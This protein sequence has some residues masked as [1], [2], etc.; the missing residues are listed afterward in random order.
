M[1]DDR[2]IDRYCIHVHNYR[3]KGE[4]STYLISLIHYAL[5]STGRSVPRNVTFQAYIQLLGYI[6]TSYQGVCVP[7]LALPSRVISSQWILKMV[8]YIR[9]R[10]DVLYLNFHSFPE[11]LLHHVTHSPVLTLHLIQSYIPSVPAYSQF[12]SWSSFLKD[13]TR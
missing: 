1:L 6:R 9:I 4:M 3:R 13:F 5:M 8:L 11:S 10:D 7:C 12:F 2:Q